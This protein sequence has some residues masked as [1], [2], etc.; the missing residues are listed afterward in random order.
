MFRQAMAMD[1]R[2][3]GEEH[4]YVAIDMYNLAG[5]LRDQGNNAEA[6][7][8]L[9]VSTVPGVDPNFAFI[10]R[11]VGVRLTSTTVAEFGPEGSVTMRV[12]NRPGEGETYTPTRT[13]LRGVRI[14][15]SGAVPPLQ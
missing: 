5:V 15:D 9:V 7:T 12:E 2:L 1:R 11:V 14:A 3:M 10:P 4:P 6:E 8:Q 13:I